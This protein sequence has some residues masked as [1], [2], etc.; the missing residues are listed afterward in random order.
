MLNHLEQANAKR[1]QAAIALTSMITT[2]RQAELLDTHTS[3]K[4]GLEHHL[5]TL[6]TLHGALSQGTFRLLILGDMKRGKSTFLN[7]L[8]GEQLLPSDVNPCTAVLTIVRYGSEKTVTIHFKSGR[9]PMVIDFATFK[10]D[11]TIDPTESKILEDK[12][13]QAFP[14]VSHAVV[15]YPLPLLHQGLEFIDTPGL[16]D[17][18]TRNKVV[19]DYLDNCHAV[20]FLL[21][22]TQPFTLDEKRYLNNSLKGRG[23]TIFFLI[24]EW[25]RLKANLMDPDDADEL[26]MAEERVRQLFL[27]QLEP[28]CFADGAVGGM[29]GEVAGEAASEVLNGADLYD[30]RVFEISALQALRARVKAEQVALEQVDLSGTGFPPF[31]TALQDFLGGDRLFAE[32]QRVGAIA[33]QI[34]G[35]VNAA[36]ERRIPLLGQPTEEVEKRIESVQT[37]FQVLTDIR[38]KYRSLI[39]QMCGQKANEIADSFKTY[40]LKLEDTFEADFVASQ[41]NLDFLSFLD[42]KNRAAFQREFQRAFERYINDRLAAW[43]FMAKQDL[44]KAFTELQESS[45]EYKN[46]YE[47][48]VQAMQEKLIGHRIYLNDRERP[49]AGAVWADAIPGLFDA[50]PDG[51]NSS[52]GRFNYFWQQVLQGVLVS[53]CISIALAMLGVIFSSLILNVLGVL[54]VG[55][56][57]L[58]VQAEVVRQRFLKTTKQQFAKHLPK[59]AEEQ[60]R[61]VYQGV[62]QC[63]DVYEERVI[64]NITQDIDART[65]ELDNLLAQKDSQ[66]LDNNQE[67]QRLT[68]LK[69]DIGEAVENLK[70]LLNR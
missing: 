6:N 47:A 7:A 43:E 41:P 66:S 18:E 50:I 12:Q 61:P 62:E 34:R 9:P 63:F 45:Q 13:E 30:R 15:E 5:D 53:V 39:R 57:V 31:L 38:D 56:G 40:I 24:N 37:E 8:L 19:L 23:L 26:A 49:Q 54:M 59:I 11:Y 64:G 35:Q 42:Q 20:L 25:D 32:L 2:I 27:A 33:H 28:Y 68:Q 69:K 14:D 4:L 44:S 46:A 3:G 16:N 70:G 29:A 21:S 60:W 51:L 17:T 1:H 22:A 52:V 58:A 10:R 36:I 67:Q 55:G 65:I 48:A